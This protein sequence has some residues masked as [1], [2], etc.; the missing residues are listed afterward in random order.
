MKATVL[1]ESS[2][3]FIFSLGYLHYYD[4][5]KCESGRCCSLPFFLKF[6]IICHALIHFK[7]VYNLARNLFTSHPYL[8]LFQATNN[9]SCY[10]AD[11]DNQNFWYCDFA[12]GYHKNR[13]KSRWFYRK[14]E[15]VCFCM[16]DPFMCL[17]HPETW[18]IHFY[19]FFV[20]STC[21][22]HDMLVIL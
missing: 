14:T 8:L 2:S 5:Y 13:N 15:E 18:V 17:F 20:F 3:Y 4:T 22:S 1:A 21:L 16:K 12:Q 10:K 7:C 9:S 6:S 11:K 19:L